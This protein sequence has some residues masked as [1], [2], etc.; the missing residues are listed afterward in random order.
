MEAEPFRYRSDRRCGGPEGRGVRDVR[1]AQA[2]GAAGLVSSYFPVRGG[3]LGTLG[4]Y[5]LVATP[6]G[7]RVA[8]IVSP[9]SNGPSSPAEILVIDTRTGGHSLW[10]GPR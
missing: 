4:A 3:A 1:R 8:V 5:G 9:G 7:S 2:A 6:D 10:L